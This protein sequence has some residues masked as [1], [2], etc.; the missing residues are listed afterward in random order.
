MKNIIK[1]SFTDICVS[2]TLILISSLLASLF[3][4]VM[5]YTPAQRLFFYDLLFRYAAGL[6]VFSVAVIVSHHF[7]MQTELFSASKAMRR[8]ISTLIFALCAFFVL[9]WGFSP[10]F[11]FPVV[12]K[13]YILIG[14]ASFI[15]ISVIV[16]IIC[17]AVEDKIAKKDAEMINKRLNELREEK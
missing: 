15:F 16:M 17:F 9:L 1:K 2:L 4:Y 11:L 7:I 3:P 14:I 6:S 10:F 8:V 13:T 5:S 12:S